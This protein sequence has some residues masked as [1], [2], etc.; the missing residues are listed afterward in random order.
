MTS[1]YT[2]MPQK[3]ESASS[4]QISALNR[5][6]GDERELLFAALEKLVNMGDS[7]GEVRSLRARRPHFFPAWVYD[8]GEYW[9][10]KDP[11]V[12]PPIR[13][14]KEQLRKIWEGRDPNGVRLSVLL[15]IE[16]PPYWHDEDFDP[17]GEPPGLIKKD[18]TFEED[19]LKWYGFVNRR[20]AYQDRQTSEGISVGAAGVLPDSPPALNWRTGTIEYEFSTDFQRSVYALMRESW[21]AK[22][23]RSC[24]RYFI[25]SKSARMYC[26][27]PCSGEAKRKR[28]L[29]YWV[30]EGRPKRE[31][32]L[33]RKAH[34]PPKSRSRRGKR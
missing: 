13:W 16:K 26:S 3:Q 34:K 4:V 24:G 21:R 8:D 6:A 20:E 2:R 23:C 17:S 9:A 11:S 33:T 15:G 32:R 10:A 25:G 28:D 19:A 22:V 18:P 12:K 14:Y 7:P 5:R 27:S 31:K 30:R 1:T 29:D